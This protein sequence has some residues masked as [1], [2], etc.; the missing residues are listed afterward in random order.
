MLWWQRPEHKE[1]LTVETAFEWA[2][3]VGRTS[4]GR[5]EEKGCSRQRGEHEQG[6]V[7]RGWWVLEEECDPGE[8]EV[9]AVEQDATWDFGYQEFPTTIPSPS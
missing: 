9:P 3:G 5:E 2:L 4:T 6:R 8:A 7:G 1:C